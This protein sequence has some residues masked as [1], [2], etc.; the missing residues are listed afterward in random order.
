MIIERKDLNLLGLE[1]KDKV[2]FFLR[3]NFTTKIDR[4]VDIF[5][6]LTYCQ[7]SPLYINDKW[8]MVKDPYRTMS[9]ICYCGE[10]YSQCLDRYVTGVGLCELAISSQIPIVRNFVIMLM[11]KYL[12]KPLGSVDKMPARLSG[13]VVI[14]LND[15]A[16]S[17]RAQFELA[18]GI[19]IHQ[20]LVLESELAGQ[21][22]N[23]PQLFETL[24]KYKSFHLF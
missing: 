21:T 9:R 23:S 8:T 2:D 11:S 10:Q 20:Q 18:F 13:N 19:S 17:T 4:I 16:T 7:S 3:F 6:Q 15:I 1:G 24:E 5:Q 12:A 14:D 22:T